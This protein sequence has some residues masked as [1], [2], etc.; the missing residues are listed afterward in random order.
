MG[1]TRLDRLHEAMREAG[2]D[3]TALGD[4]VGC[5]QGAIS[6]ILVGRTRQSRLLPDIA[7]ALDVSVEWLLDRSD[8]RKAAAPISNQAEL[9]ERYNI[10]FVPEVREDRIGGGGADVPLGEE[11]RS[12][13]P[14][15]R[16]WLGPMRSE[17]HTSE[18]Q[19]QSNLVCRL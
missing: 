13:V 9:E 14:L 2:L 7:R 11:L 15:P 6:Q 1:K 12:L 19:S 17:E 18:L 10:V 16:D 3:Q 5:T 4:R 8:D